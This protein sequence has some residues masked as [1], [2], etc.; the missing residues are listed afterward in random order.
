MRFLQADLLF[1]I[2]TEPIPHGI[3]VVEDDGRINDIVHP[4]ISEENHRQLV[5]SP[6]LERFSGALTPGFINAHCHLELSHLKGGISGQKGLPDFLKSVTKYRQETD[7]RI[8]DAMKTADDEM[9]QGGIVGV[10]DISNRLDS[11]PVKRQSQ[12]R[13]HTFVEVFDLHPDMA[14]VR[15]E[16]ACQVEQAFRNHGLSTSIVPHAPYTVSEKLFRKISEHTLLH[17]GLLSIHNQETGSEDDFFMTGTGVLADFLKST[18]RYDTWNPTGISSLRT[19]LSR[20][21]AINRLLLV[22][23]TFTDQLD[24][25]W[26]VDHRPTTYW[27]LC[28][29]ANLYIENRLPDL[30][31]LIQEESNVLVGT[32]SLASNDKLSLLDELRVLASAAPWLTINRLLKMVTLDAA[33]YFGWEQELGSFEM[34]KTPGVN[35]LAYQTI[36]SSNCFSKDTKVTRIC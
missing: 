21:P 29:K 4:L 31:T 35:L 3:L 36:A 9:Q 5:G 22:H 16:Q 20:L 24:Y 18:G 10:G 11:L 34:G 27:C 8:V 23:N 7:D 15:F 17:N 14:D 19:C 12:L 2:L 25:Q 32:D 13:Y 6:M 26:T 33:R 28:P 1:P 30:T